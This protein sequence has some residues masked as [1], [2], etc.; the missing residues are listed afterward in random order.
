M[1]QV[2]LSPT[3]LRIVAACAGAEVKRSLGYCESR[4]CF[5][6][7][8]LPFRNEPGRERLKS[9]PDWRK[10]ADFVCEIVS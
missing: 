2:K 6:S 10:C 3:L 8:L 5:W 1:A 9:E 4:K 7:A